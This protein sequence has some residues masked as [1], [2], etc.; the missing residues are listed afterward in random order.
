[1][2]SPRFVCC[3]HPIPPWQCGQRAV[4]RRSVVGANCCGVAIIAGG[5]DPRDMCL[6]AR[7]QRRL[8]PGRCSFSEGAAKHSD[9]DTA[10]AMGF[11]VLLTALSTDPWRQRKNNTTATDDTDPPL[12]IINNGAA[13]TTGVGGCRPCWCS[14]QS[15]CSG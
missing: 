14:F 3:W 2:A 5:V 6:P 8:S 4:V 9:T 13:K 11:V 15:G 1:M 12:L 7:Q 10:F